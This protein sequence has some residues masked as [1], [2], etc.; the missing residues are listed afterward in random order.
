MTA[1]DR[2]E[3]LRNGAHA[4][5][6]AEHPG[7]FIDQQVAPLLIQQTIDDPKLDQSKDIVSEEQFWGDDC[8]VLF[9]AVRLR[10]FKLIDWF[11]RA[12]GVF[13]SRIARETRKHISSRPQ[14]SDDELGNYFAPHAK[15]GLIENGGIGSIRL[16]PRMIDGERCWLAT[17][18]TGFECQGGV[19]LAIPEVL[20]QKT[21]LGWGDYANIKG[22]VRFLQDAGLRNIARHVHHA[23]PLIVFVDDLESVKIQRSEVPIIISPVALFESTERDVNRYERAK[24]TFVQCASRPDSELDAAA[25]WI[26]KYTAKFKGR[27]ITNWDEQRPTLADAR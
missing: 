21:G 9:G 7:R 16:R 8:L 11:P 10:K 5:T 15:M 23:R 17:A 3:W 6:P 24:Y 4:A 2:M 1:N 25:E 27:V 20:L 19:P 18:L 22:R 12:P 13:W 26:E 14:Y